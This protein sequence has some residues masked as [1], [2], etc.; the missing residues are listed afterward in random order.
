[1]GTAASGGLIFR[2]ARQEDA[3][4][5]YEIGTLCFSDAWQKATVANDMKGAHSLYFV[6]EEAGE[7]IAYACWWFVVDE[8]Q[9]VN[10]GVRP[11]SRRRG[12]A[13]ELLREGLAESA[14]RGM[15]SVYLEVRVSNLS[16]QALYRKHGF[17]VKALR[18]KVYDLP[19]EDGYI[20][21]RTI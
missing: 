5:V 9:L 4:A 16:A 21:A 12:I 15:A 19:R 6:A 17:S 8:A 20:M 18:P 10:I 11:T 3:E 1:M 13:E 2:R 7:V 14:A